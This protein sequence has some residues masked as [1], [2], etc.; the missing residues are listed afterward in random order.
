MQSI[1]KLTVRR[2]SNIRTMASPS[3][4]EAH[5]FLHGISLV[6]TTIFSEMLSSSCTYV[7]EMIIRNT[8][9][10]ITRAWIGLA[11]VTGTQP[12]SRMFT[13]YLTFNRTQNVFVVLSGEKNGFAPRSQ[14]YDFAE[15]TGPVRE[16]I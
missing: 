7:K 13:S 11:H 16:K 14:A 3:K 15:A 8:V 6:N 10:E 5:I 12:F 4:F 9:Q 2:S 1:L